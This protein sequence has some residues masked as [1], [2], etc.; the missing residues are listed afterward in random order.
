MKYRFATWEGEISLSWEREVDII[1]Q[2]EFNQDTEC[3]ITSVD[4]LRVDGVRSK[5][6][7]KS[8]A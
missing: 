7:H 8:H 6:R 1:R 4:T 3:V 5:K 2:N